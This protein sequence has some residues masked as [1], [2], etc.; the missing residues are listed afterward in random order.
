MRNSATS[1]LLP[2]STSRFRSGASFSPATAA[3]PGLFSQPHHD[4]AA[5][6]KAFGRIPLAGFFAQGNSAHRQAEL[7]ARL[8]GEYCACFEAV[9]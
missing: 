9:K 6:E 2:K 1:L 7:H 3:A 5:I 4:A 8:Y